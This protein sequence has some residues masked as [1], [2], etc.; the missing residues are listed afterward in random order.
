[1]RV[2]KRD[3]SHFATSRWRKNAKCAPIFGVPLT[4]Q[5]FP[6]YYTQS[7]I[8][9][10]DTNESRVFTISPFLQHEMKFGTM[11][12]LQ[13]GARVDVTILKARDPFANVPAAGGNPSWQNTDS[14]VMGAPNFNI[15]P[16]FRPVPWLTTY[17]TYNYS[18]STGV[19]NGGGVV[20]DGIPR[21]RESLAKI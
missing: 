18:Q 3:C 1:M 7:G 5:G 15:S 4:A 9:N 19:A 13:Y 21:A 12:G 6:N 11:F 14:T 20:M 16:T 17:F 10:G 8:V 2:T